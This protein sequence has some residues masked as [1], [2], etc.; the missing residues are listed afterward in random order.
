MAG[1]WGGTS[2]STTTGAG[3]GAATGALVGTAIAPGVGT[4]VGA[5]IGG[6]VGGVQGNIS[7]RAKQSQEEAIAAA[8]DAMRKELARRQDQSRQ[9][10][11]I[12]GDIQGAG[13]AGQQKAIAAHADIAGQIERSTGTAQNLA[14][15]G[16]T[17]LGHQEAA[18]VRAS[19]ASRGLMG[20]SL[21]TSNRQS[22]LGTYLGNVAGTAGVADATRQ[23][24]W[25]G[26]N[27]EKLG[28]QNQALQGVDINPQLSNMNLSQN[29]RQAQQGLPLLAAG[30]LLQTGGQ[31]GGQYL[32]GQMAPQQSAL[33]K[34]NFSMGNPGGGSGSSGPVG[35]MTS[36]GRR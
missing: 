36:L 31:L 5:G 24:G 20:S 1:G 35:A 32:M 11:G 26:V 18:G 19:A 12:Y 29:I 30:N 13:A 7:G 3:T 2:Q 34:T 27:R 17:A 10:A 25:E 4:L 9:V 23:S 16:T 15:Q 21:D 22:L 28:L 8:E 6:L 33:Q 14:Q